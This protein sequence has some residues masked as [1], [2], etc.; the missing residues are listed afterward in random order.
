[1]KIKH[2]ISKN[3]SQM[4]QHINFRQLFDLQVLIFNAEYF[5]K[6]EYFSGHLYKSTS[7]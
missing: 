4:N 6:S 1:M 3:N 7:S 5:G 2:E